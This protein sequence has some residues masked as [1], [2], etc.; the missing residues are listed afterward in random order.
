MENK[1]L[2]P[3]NPSASEILDQQS[4]DVQE[5]AQDNEVDDGTQFKKAKR[6]SL[7]SM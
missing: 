3:E 7:Y 5:N 2:L 4:N 1:P 6:N